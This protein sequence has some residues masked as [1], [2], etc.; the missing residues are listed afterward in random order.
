MKLVIG[1]VIFHIGNEGRVNYAPWGNMQLVFKAIYSIIV[2]EQMHPFSSVLPLL[3][4]FRNQ[5]PC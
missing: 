3:V 5:Q 2:K 4:L 1:T